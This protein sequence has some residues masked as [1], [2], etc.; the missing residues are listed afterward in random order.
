MYLVGRGDVV[1]LDACIGGF[2]VVECVVVG[3]EVD[4]VGCHYWVRDHVAGVV[5][6]VVVVDV[7]YVYFGFAH[8]V[9]VGKIEVVVRVEHD[10][11][12]FA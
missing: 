9:E 3:R 10:V 5:V 1:G 7:V 2:G 11:V 4:A 8:F 6:G 12:W